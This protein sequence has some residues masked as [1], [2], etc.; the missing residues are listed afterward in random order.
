MQTQ[1]AEFETLIHPLT[2]GPQACPPGTHLAD[3]GTLPF[4]HESETQCEA[5]QGKPA[6][7]QVLWVLVELEI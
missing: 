7:A 5:C 4:Y 2:V 1:F 3:Q 6:S